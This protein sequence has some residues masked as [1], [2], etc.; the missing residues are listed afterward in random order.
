M[1]SFTGYLDNPGTSPA[2][3]LV[4]LVY[5][6]LRA[7]AQCEMNQER[8]GHTLQATALVHE[9]FIRLSEAGVHWSGPGSFYRAAAEAMRRILV[10]HARSRGRVKRGG[11]RRR[12]P[13]NVVDLAADADPDQILALDEYLCDLEREYPQAAE[14]VWLRFYVGLT[15]DRTAEILGQSPRQV[16]RLW[17]FGRA[18]LHR[19]M[20]GARPDR[21][22]S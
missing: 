3:Y 14:V 8:A 2:A 4:E 7:V 6:Q 16:D 5:A 1:V 19:R 22:A 11:E 20:S 17:A 18:W 21:S 10:E 13:I 15:I 12:V 9:A